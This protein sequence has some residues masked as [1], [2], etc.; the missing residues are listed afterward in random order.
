[1]HL[2]CWLNDNDEFVKLRKAEGGRSKREEDEKR[3]RFS[4]R[5]DFICIHNHKTLT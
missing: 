4:N 1:M 3:T 2:P 5:C